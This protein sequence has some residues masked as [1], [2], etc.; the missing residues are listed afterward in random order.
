MRIHHLALRTEDITRLVIFYEN[1]LGL[2]VHKREA[3]RVWLRAGEAV[4][5]LERRA[6]GEP[7]LAAGTL[8]L[9]AFAVTEA[10]RDAFV[11]RFATH[12]V[13]IEARTEHT[14]YVRDPDG[15]RVGVSSYPIP[16]A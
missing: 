10:E 14:L 6:P 7:T 8:E 13:T 5:M 4:L 11:A 12:G 1:A 15:R 2:P 16:A 9:V 3:D